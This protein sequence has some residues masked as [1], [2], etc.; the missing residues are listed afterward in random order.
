MFAPNVEFYHDQGGVTTTRAQEVANTCRYIRGKVGREL[1]KR[2]LEAHPI[3]HCGAI[4][5]GEHRFCELVTGKCEGVAKFLIIWQQRSS[6]WR[7][8]RVLSFGHRA[9]H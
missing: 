5:T 7:A 9:V 3:K 4:A 8:T 2:M 1:V 6:G